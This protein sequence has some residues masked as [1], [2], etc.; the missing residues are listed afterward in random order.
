MRKLCDL[1]LEERPSTLAFLLGGRCRRSRRKR[2]VEGHFVPS[3]AS[4]R[5]R[6]R[7]SLSCHPGL[8]AS[9]C[10]GR[11]RAVLAALPA[12]PAAPLPK[13]LASLRFSGALKNASRRISASSSCHPER[14]GA[15]GP[16]SRRISE[17][18]NHPC[19]LDRAWP[20]LLSSRPSKA[21][22][23]I[24][25]RTQK[26]FRTRQKLAADAH[27]LSKRKFTIRTYR[28]TISARST[29]IASS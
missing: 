4:F 25:H 27:F 2:S 11:R 5:P 6:G 24:L 12:A 9:R 1:L 13:N 29:R 17:N 23:G 14:S 15:T 3:L 28:W 19:H 21:S 16:R 20:F 8:V 18:K 7:S 22:G 26:P 10:H